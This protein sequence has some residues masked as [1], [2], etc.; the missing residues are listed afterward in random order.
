MSSEQKNLVKKATS[1]GLRVRFLINDMRN[2]TEV[3]FCNGKYFTFFK[4][5]CHYLSSAKTITKCT[6]A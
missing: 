1:L 6:A 2:E 5:A 4:D 3:E